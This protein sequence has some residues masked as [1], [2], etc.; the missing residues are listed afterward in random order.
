MIKGGRKGKG[1]VRKRGEGEK[2]DVQN[3]DIN[4]K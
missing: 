2:G 1:R 4:C 3:E